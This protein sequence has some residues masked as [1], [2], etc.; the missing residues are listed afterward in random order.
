[1]PQRFLWR[2]QDLRRHV[3]RRLAA[4]SFE[5]CP[6]VPSV[7]LCRADEVDAE[8]FTGDLDVAIPVAHVAEAD[9]LIG[10]A[11][12]EAREVAA[13]EERRA[14][15][16]AARERRRGRGSARRRAAR[17]LPA[18]RARGHRLAAAAGRRGYHHPRAG[19]DH[20]P[21]ADLQLLPATG[22][23][24]KLVDAV[25]R[26]ET[27]SEEGHKALV[28]SQYVD[29]RFGGSSTP[30]P[31]S[32]RSARVPSR[33]ASTACCGASRRSSTRWWTTFPS[34]WRAT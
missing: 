19:A 31:S 23:W 25:E 3:A 11:A 12:G 4:S 18:R 5:I 8:L 28:F 27:L 13:Q 14:A 10:Q 6:R 33:S 1:V 21:Q 2:A 34:S 9:A 16:V 26:L 17:E 22:E 15:A 29:D 32:A 24:A 7:L 30:S 20:P